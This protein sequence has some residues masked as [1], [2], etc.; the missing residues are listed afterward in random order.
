MFR[1]DLSQNELLELDMR[2]KGLNEGLLKELVLAGLN[3][4]GFSDA[5]RYQLYVSASPILGRDW[6]RLSPLMSKWPFEVV[7][8]KSGYEEDI[9]EVRLFSYFPNA[10]HF[11]RPNLHN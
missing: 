7:G 5:Q 10:S 6:I 8:R 9:V 1:P 11:L 3:A 4:Y 2:E